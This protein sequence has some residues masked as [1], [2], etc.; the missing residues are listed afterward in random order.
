MHTYVL[1]YLG[2]LAI[3]C[4]MDFIW[5][6]MIAKNIYKSHMGSLMLA[7]PNMIAAVIFYLLYIVGLLVFAIT[8]AL[9]SQSFT[10]ALYLGG[11]LGLIAYA[12][13]DLTNL[14]TL[15]G[16]STSL[17]IIDI[18]WGVFVSSVSSVAGFLV[19]KMFG[20]I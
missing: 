4:A 2:A 6:T 12:S 7:E 19:V 9:R 5:L 8:P 16:W 10:T 1:A 3:F 18:A 15:K 14:A 11:F 17:T 20:K 13:Y